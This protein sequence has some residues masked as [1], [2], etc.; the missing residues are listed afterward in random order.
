[1]VYMKQ[2]WRCSCE[3]HQRQTVGDKENGWKGV[4]KTQSKRNKTSDWTYGREEN[5][6]SSRERYC[7]SDCPY[8]CP[9][10]EWASG[11]TT[12][13]RSLCGAAGQDVNLLGNA[14]K[15]YGCLRERSLERESALSPAGLGR[16]SRCNPGNTVTRSKASSA[17]MASFSHGTEIKREFQKRLLLPPPTAHPPLSG[18]G[19]E[20]S[21]RR[22]ILLGRVRGVWNAEFGGVPS[23]TPI[24]ILTPAPGF[25]QLPNLAAS[26]AVR[27]CTS[28]L[29]SPYSF[30]PGAPFPDGE[31]LSLLLISV[32]FLVFFTSSLGGGGAGGAQG[33][34]RIE[35]F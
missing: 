6:G 5:K 8:R 30:W 29:G 2:D 21:L 15:Q 16:P 10:S 17:T 9:Q 26:A 32:L 12:T 18:R 7:K 1:M 35:T 13:P 34:E 23:P 19:A 28:A 27:F 4:R 31:G 20:P 33:F 24:C 25:L 11:G 14:Y 3:C 22:G